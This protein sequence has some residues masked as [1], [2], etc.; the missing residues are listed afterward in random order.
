MPVCDSWLSLKT[1]AQYHSYMRATLAGL[2]LATIV[3]VTAYG[4]INTIAPNW[5]FVGTPVKWKSPPRRAELHLHT[6]PTTLLV[7]YPNGV[8]ASVTC[9]LVEQNEG[10]ITI[11]H[12]DGYV[13]RKGTWKSVNSDLIANATVVFRTLWL[14]SKEE[15]VSPHTEQ[16]KVKQV[17]GH[18]ELKAAGGQKYAPL[19]RFADF[20]GLTRLITTTR[21]P[22]PQPDW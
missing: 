3:A 8:Y 20:D 15:P 17:R 22:K 18:T 5:V 7:V 11:S 10:A 13:V 6:A 9:L 1:Q 19:A 21:L 12:E 2:A 16:F 4:Q 14:V